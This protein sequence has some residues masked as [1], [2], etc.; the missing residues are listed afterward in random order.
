M[1]GFL[2]VFADECR[3]G[4]HGQVRRRWC[5][6]GV[7][8]IQPLQIRYVWRYLCLWVSPT[9]A[10]G[11]R[12]QTHCK[13]E[14]LVETVEAWREDGVE[15][16]VWDNAPSHHAKLVRATGVPLIGLPSYSPELNPAER[17]F[18]EVRRVVEGYVYPDIEAKQAAADRFLQELAADPARV[19]SLAGWQ[20]ITEE[21]AKL[22]ATNTILG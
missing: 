12:W 8:L 2:V 5:P 21:L 11:W 15:A 9:G 16:I 18:E 13:K 17:V 22:P 6:V 1:L 4:L 3:L 19:R 10:L 20:W 14:L 7:K